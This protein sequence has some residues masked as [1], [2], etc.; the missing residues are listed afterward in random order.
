MTDCP[1]LIDMCQDE[2]GLCDIDLVIIGEEG[3]V[4]YEQG[5]N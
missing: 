4:I 1:E 3:E 5:A 2:N